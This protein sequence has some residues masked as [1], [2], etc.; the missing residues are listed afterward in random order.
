MNIYLNLK[1]LPALFK[2]YRFSGSHSEF[3]K[4]HVKISLLVTP[5]ATNFSHRGDAVR[6]LITTLH[7]I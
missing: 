4:N 7:E 1:L 6:K 2:E 3:W 5:P